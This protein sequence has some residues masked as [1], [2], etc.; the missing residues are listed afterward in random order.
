M[1]VMFSVQIQNQMLSRNDQ[2]GQLIPGW[3]CWV[4]RM[5]IPRRRASANGITGRLDTRS[6][7][8]SVCLGVAW[9]P[10]CVRAI[11]GYGRLPTALGLGR[12]FFIFDLIFWIIF[13]VV[14]DTHYEKFRSSCRSVFND[15]AV[16][17]PLRNWSQEYSPA[18]N[19]EMVVPA[20]GHRVTASHRT[21]VLVSSPRNSTV[22]CSVSTPV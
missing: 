19:Y 5:H 8:C 21:I 9:C 17:R 6:S 1:S 4:Q 3:Q 12:S 7:L 10:A 22:H 13:V 15:R 2:D 14:L 20:K 16:I 11:G 18:S